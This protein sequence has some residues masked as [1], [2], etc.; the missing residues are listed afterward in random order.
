ML[1]ASK[2]RKRAWTIKTHMEGLSLKLLIPESSH[3]CVNT[4]WAPFMEGGGPSWGEVYAIVWTLNNL[5]ICFQYF[6]GALSRTKQTTHKRW[7]RVKCSGPTSN[8]MQGLE[9]SRS[10]SLFSTTLNK[11]FA[12]PNTW[13]TSLAHMLFSTS[14]EVHYHRLRL[15]VRVICRNSVVSFN[16]QIHEL[17]NYLKVKA[18]VIRGV[19]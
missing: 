19:Q 13:S 18:T 2:M 10:S 11:V 15:R 7:Y 6:Q 17:K 1:H 9:Q 5:S 3:D 8:H 16:L 4:S 12:S 14:K